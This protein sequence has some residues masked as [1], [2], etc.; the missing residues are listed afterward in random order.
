[1]KLWTG[2]AK[3]V[4]RKQRSLVGTCYINCH[5]DLVYGNA[6]VMVETETARQGDEEW[7]QETTRKFQQKEKE[8]QVS[9]VTDFLRRINVFLD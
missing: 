5:Q 2:I 7:R 8:L 4:R 1:L 6:S 9:Y 3:K